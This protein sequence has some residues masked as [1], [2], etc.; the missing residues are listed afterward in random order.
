MS[1]KS[2]LSTAT[3]YDKDLVFGYAKSVERI[4]SMN[5]VAVIQYLILKFFIEFDLFI[6]S[7]PNIQIKDNGAGLIRTSGE[8]Y[9]NT[10]ISQVLCSYPNVYKWSI[11][12]SK[13]ISFGV[14]EK[15]QFDLNKFITSQGGIFYSFL[16]GF[17][18]SS[19][20]MTITPYATWNKS[21]KIGILLDMKKGMLSLYINGVD[22]G[23][24]FIKIDI[25]KEY[26]F[27]CC[28]PQKNNFLEIL[29]F[30]TM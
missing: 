7:S 25:K 3:A 23:I 16:N 29:S 5:I 8:T 4:Y 20:D 12:C 18:S 14:I 27:W 2:I 10:N 17:R 1:L 9:D 21:D 30:K 6:V 22:Q 13:L 19:Y 24:A 26:Q 15:L 28:L 11:S